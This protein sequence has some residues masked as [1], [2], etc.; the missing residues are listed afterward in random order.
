MS[1][2]SENLGRGAKRKKSKAPS[3]DGEDLYQLPPFGGD[4]QHREVLSAC[5]RAE[6]SFETLGIEA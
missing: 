4:C 3:N 1:G 2:G 5:G 6:H